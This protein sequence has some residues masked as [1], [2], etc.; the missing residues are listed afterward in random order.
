MIMHLL[1]LLFAVWIVLA[2][3]NGA[4]TALLTRARFLDGFFYV[5]AFPFVAIM[6]LAPRR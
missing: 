4:L 6:T 3:L 1:F 2:I 5:I